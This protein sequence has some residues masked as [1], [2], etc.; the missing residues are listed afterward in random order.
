MSPRFVFCA[1]PVIR[2]TERFSVRS[3]TVTISSFI[4]SSTLFSVSA[5]CLG[6]SWFTCLEI[7][8][9]MLRVVVEGSQTHQSLCVR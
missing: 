1:R 6:F 9:R 8:E 4:S 5:S 7:L 2:G 3:E